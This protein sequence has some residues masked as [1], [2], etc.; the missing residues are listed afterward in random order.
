MSKLTEGDLPPYILSQVHENAK[1]LSPLER[2]ILI[3]LSQNPKIGRV[4]LLHMI[5]E[6]GMDVSEGKI[7][8]TIHSMA[9]QGLVHTN[10][11]KGGCE[12]TGKGETYL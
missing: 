12:I 10:R 11:T 5:Q 3:C 1:D 9:E 4:T 6:N 7:R 2:Q 8:S